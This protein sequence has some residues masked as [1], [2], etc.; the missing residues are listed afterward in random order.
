MIQI[1]SLLEMMLY[2]TMIIATVVT[3]ISEIVNTVRELIGW[4]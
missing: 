4:K 1:I 3:V 2:A